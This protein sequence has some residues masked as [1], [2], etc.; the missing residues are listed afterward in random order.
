MFGYDLKSYLSFLLITVL[1]CSMVFITSFGDDILGLFPNL[2]PYAIPATA[3]AVIV[4]IVFLLFKEQVDDKRSREEFVS[5]IT[6][7]FRT[8]LTGVKWAIEMLRNNI[9]EQQKQDILLHMENSNQRLMEI[10][11]LTVG[12]AQFDKHLDYAYEATGFREV[13]DTALQKYGD[14]ARD[15]NINFQINAGGSALPL[16]IVDK[17][18]IQ[19]VVD[20]LIDNAVKY[21][22]AGGTITV[23]FSQSGRYLTLSIHDTGIGVSWSDRG[24]VFKKFYRSRNA[25]AA[26]TEG[27]GLGLYAAKTIINK[28][29]GRIWFESKGVGKGTTFFVALKIKA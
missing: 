19:F 13:V 26:D 17:R 24:H 12:F 27:M 15:K 5:V 20:M 2:Y 25:K 18:K 10:V 4:V 1:V 16:V 6:H 14:K 23:S 9:T 7:K 8:P 21:T 22:P 29:R 28:H 11:D 3:S